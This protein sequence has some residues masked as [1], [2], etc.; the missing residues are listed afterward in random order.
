MKYSIITINYNNKVGLE[1]T[2]QSVINQTFKDYEYIIIDGNSTDGSKDVI[3]KYQSYF[4]Y[5]VSEPDAGIYFAMNKG[6]LMAHGDYCNYLNSGDCYSDNTVLAHIANLSSDADILSGCHDENLA[7]NQGKNGVI[8]MLDLFKYSYNHQESFIKRELCLKYPYDTKYRIAADRK[9]FIELFITE[10]CSFKF[11]DKVIIDVEPGGT[12]NRFQKEC[13]AEINRIL[14]DYLPP[15]IYVD[16]VRY[17][18]ADCPLLDLTP[19]LN[20]TTGIQKLVYNFALLML[21][22]RRS[23]LY[24]VFMRKDEVCKKDYIFS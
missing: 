10:N 17:A 23:K 15:R 24:K 4:N 16:Y 9:F 1:R 20:E 2:I 18:K 14:H 13:R 11:T 21:K 12:S 22:I 5:W 3:Q 19:E 8:T 6:T 7:R